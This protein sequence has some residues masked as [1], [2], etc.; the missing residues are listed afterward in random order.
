MDSAYLFDKYI[1]AVKGFKKAQVVFSPGRDSKPS[2]LL[3]DLLSKERVG[4]HPGLPEWG[5]HATGQVE[6]P[7]QQPEAPR[8]AEAVAA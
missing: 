2:P 1:D 5:G 8:M 7:V 3:V 4:V 6:T